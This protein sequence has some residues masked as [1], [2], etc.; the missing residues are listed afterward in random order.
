MRLVKQLLATAILLLILVGDSEAAG[1]YYVRPNG[2]TATNCTGLADAD[3]D[4]SGTGE[5]CAFN[6]PFW[7]TGVPV[8]CGGTS[9]PLAGGETAIIYPKSGG[10]DMGY[11]AP[12]TAGST[13]Y[14]WDCH[15][16]PI[17]SGPNS[18]TKTKIYGSNYASCSSISS[19]TELYGKERAYFVL[20]LRG[21]DNVDVRC[22]N[23]TD[24]SQC[25]HSGL[26]GEGLA[27]PAS[28]PYGD[29]ALVGLDST[30]SANVNLKDIW[31]HGFASEGAGVDTPTDWTVENVNLWAN[32]G[33][34][35]NFNGSGAGG[36]TDQATGT[37]TFTG[38]IVA[39]GGCIES[40]PPVSHDY[41]GITLYEP[42]SCC[43][44]SQSAVCISDGLGTESNQAS[45]IFDG[46]KYVRNVGDGLDLLYHDIDGGSGLVTV[47]NSKFL[48]NSGNQVKVG[49][50]A[51]LYNLAI[52]AE[53]NYFSGKSY[54]YTGDGG[55]SDHCRAGGNAI[56][57]AFQT[58]TD[59]YVE[60]ITVVNTANGEPFTITARNIANC[61][62]GNRLEI[63]NSIFTTTNGLGWINID[64]SCSSATVQQDHSVIWGFLSNPT[65]T[66][67]VFTNPGLS[68]TIIGS[69]QN[70]LIPSTSSSAYN[71]ADE[72]AAN[73]T[74]D[75]MFGFDRGAAWDAGAIEFGS[76]DTGES[77]GGGGSSTG[78]NA[79]I[80]GK[81]SLT[82]GR[83]Q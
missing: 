25:R 74:S 41:D 4:G 77:G 18:S 67:N 36:T 17:P 20:N 47:K 29:Y 42:E 40:Y 16:N 49:G 58:G 65:G 2:S 82:G 48:K 81:A 7:L 53:C 34:N 14:P 13:S 52:D 15:M 78:I 31:I 75:D 44:Q 8:N 69:D 83:I 60:G 38:G 32:G 37:M 43:S 55:F 9:G 80:T 57:I 79:Y 6:H 5:A 10:Y 63:R 45:W 28:Y 71:I 12:N 35:W 46:V 62:G 21:S 72:T 66:G 22:L 33:I 73:Q 19:A 26:A 61:A 27:C 54:T 11:G 76:T 68:G 24:H 56:S 30:G 70:F 59:V 50:N 39:H 51:I 64:G 23:V 1:P 3:Y